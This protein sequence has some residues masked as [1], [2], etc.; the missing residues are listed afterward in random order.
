MTIKQRM[1]KLVTLVTAATV[2]VALIGLVAI[3]LLNSASKRMVMVDDTVINLLEG[4]GASKDFFAK[5][6][7]T[8]LDLTNNRVDTAIALQEEVAGSID[9]EQFDSLGTILKAYKTDFNGVAALYEKR[10]FTIELG[11][12]GQMRLPII[13]AEKILTGNG[14]SDASFRYLQELRRHEKDYLLRKEQKYVDLHEKTMANFRRAVAGSGI[15]PALVNQ[16]AGLTDTYEKAFREIVTLDQEIAAATDKMRSSVNV[17][18]PLSERVKVDLTS[19][20]SRTTSILVTLFVVCA[21]AGTGTVLVM[22]KRMGNGISAPIVGLTEVMGVMAGGDYT[23]AVDYQDREDELGEMSRAVEVFKKNG[24]EVRRLEAEQKARE[25]KEAEERQRVRLQLAND[26]EASVG[27]VVNAVSAAA[28]ELQVTA[29]SMSALSE[30]TSSQAG[31]VA[32]AAEQSSVNLGAVAAATE[33]LSGSIT[34]INR[35]VKLSSEI[36]SKAVSRGEAANETMGELTRSMARIG[37]VVELIKSVADQ[38]NLLA[39]N[40][41]IEAAR[42]G[43]AGKG[44]AVVADEVKSLASQ[45]TRATEEIREQIAAVQRDTQQAATGI[46]D[47]ARVIHENDE[48]VTSIAGAMEEQGVTT[49]EISR[50]V[51]QAATGTQEVSHN[52]NSLNAAA[53][54][55]G[56]ASGQVLSAARELSRNAGLLSKEMQSFLQKVRQG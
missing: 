29:Q 1:G 32:A 42:A 9:T 3:S 45:T 23:R 10:G 41:T 47:I 28:E 33:Q 19:S 36:A 14:G 39:L 35:Q 27:Q 4:R 56:S 48:V 11:L 55:T 8:D 52:V 21:A 43:E 53:E 15:S 22:G 24:L 7:K 46:A 38:T 16:L 37:E 44:F 18:E 13:D 26:F 40:A 12:R 34:E 54:E 20:A 25:L 51:E 49:R 31:T 17:L 6:E 5:L 50:N 30:E 2:A